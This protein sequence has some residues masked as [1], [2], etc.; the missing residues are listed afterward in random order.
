M[1]EA[2][3]ETEY[4]YYVKLLEFCRAILNAESEE[5]VET[6]KEEIPVFLREN[7]GYDDVAVD[8]YM[9]HINNIME[10]VETGEIDLNEIPLQVN[11]LQSTETVQETQNTIRDVGIATA[12]IGIG[13]GLLLGCMALRKKTAK[14]KNKGL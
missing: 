5:E 8:G 11:E 3:D 7:Y 10:K 4:E 14:K 9:T 6:I 12:G 13:L 1:R 2:T